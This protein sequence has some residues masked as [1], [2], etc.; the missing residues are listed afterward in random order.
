MPRAKCWPILLLEDE[1]L[2]ERVLTPH[3]CQA[4]NVVWDCRTYRALPG[5]GVYMGVGRI[6]WTFL[7]RIDTDDKRSQHLFEL[8]A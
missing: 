2:I 4:S 5:T 6:F 7:V 1:N 3:A 8:L